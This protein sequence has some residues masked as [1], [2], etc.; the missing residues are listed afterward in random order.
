MYDWKA[1]LDHLPRAWIM[2]SLIPTA[3]AVVAAPILKLWPA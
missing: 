1:K 3:D 2:E